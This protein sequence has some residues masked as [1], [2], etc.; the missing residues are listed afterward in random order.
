MSQERG[1]WERRDEKRVRQGGGLVN[2][3][4]VSP[5][6]ERR[7]SDSR[8]MATGSIQKHSCCECTSGSVYCFATNWHL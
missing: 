2:V 6:P 3:S 5:G 8:T 1:R 7:V 4:V